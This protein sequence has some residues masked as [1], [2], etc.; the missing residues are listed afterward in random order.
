AYQQ[1]VES[2]V[3]PEERSLLPALNS[4]QI[5]DLVAGIE[6]TDEKVG[7]QSYMARCNITFERNKV[8]EILAK[9]GV[10]FLDNVSPNV[11]VLPILQ[12]DSQVLLWEKE[13]AWKDAWVTI[14]SDAK[15]VPL[16]VPMGDLDDITLVKV[17]D[18]FSG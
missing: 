14:A 1:L 11:L 12:Q 6:V 5:N 18:A 7:E 8:R 2:V 9:A 10:Q 3:L 4:S 15:V 16:I 17:E 13:N